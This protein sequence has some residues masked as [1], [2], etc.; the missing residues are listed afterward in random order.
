MNTIKQLVLTIVVLTF[1]ATGSFAQNNNLLESVLK[2]PVSP[3]GDV[4]GASTD[5]VVNLRISMDP[6]VPGKTL[7]AGRQIR[8]TLP[9]QFVNTGLPMLPFGSPQCGV[10]VHLC[11]S[12]AVLQGWPQNPIEFSKYSLAFED[13]H[14]ILITALEDLAPVSELQ[15]GVKQIH[16]ILFGVRNPE[17]PGYYPIRVTGQTG[18]NGEEES[19]VAMVGIRPSVR[20]SINVTSVFNNTTTQRKGSIF[21]RT[22]P[23]TTT[24]LPYDFLLWNSNGEPE[25]GMR[26][27]RG[28]GTHE[29]FIVREQAVGD[30]VIGMVQI[31]SPAGADDL[32]VGSGDSWIVQAPV[33]G[34]DAG[35]LRVYF[36]TSTVPGLYKLKFSLLGGNEVES[37]VSTDPGIRFP[38]AE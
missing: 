21:Q 17:R 27:R 3:D 9:P 8:I 5:L 11:S 4:V 25:T 20:P 12:A 34:R 24:P 35:F 31:K 37:Y 6:S 2:A 15:P 10:A 23:G 19:G 33:T 13:D 16:L 18:P 29:Y 26:V 22:A 28:P 30:E 1:I 36:K 38:S 7:A 32:R 14:T